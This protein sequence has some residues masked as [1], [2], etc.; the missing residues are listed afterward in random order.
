MSIYVTRRAVRANQATASGV[1]RALAD[2]AIQGPASDAVPGHR[3][4][5]ARRESPRQEAT[6][7]LLDDDSQVENACWWAR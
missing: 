1:R 5:R 7:A 4:D 3:P 6:T 2:P